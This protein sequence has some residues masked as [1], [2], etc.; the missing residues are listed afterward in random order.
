MSGGGPCGRPRPVPMNETLTPSTGPHEDTR[1]GPHTTQPLPRPY[2]RSPV[3]VLSLYKITLRRS[4]N[5]QSTET[6]ENRLFEH[7]YFTG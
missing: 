2:A 5:E 3:R 6:L 4:G 1:K 7:T